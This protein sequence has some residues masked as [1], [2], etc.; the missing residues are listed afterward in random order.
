MQSLMLVPV[1]VSEELKQT[2]RQTQ[3]HRKNC[4]LYSRLSS[5][6]SSNVANLNSDL[7]FKENAA[8]NNVTTK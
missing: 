4:A 1:A 5:A 7:Q 8:F 2:D 6:Q 3:T